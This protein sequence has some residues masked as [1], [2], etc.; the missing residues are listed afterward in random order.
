VPRVAPLPDNDP[1]EALPPLPAPVPYGNLYNH[2][3]YKSAL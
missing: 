3:A 1:S 2:A